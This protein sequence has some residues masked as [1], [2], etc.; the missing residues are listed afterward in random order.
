MKLVG[1]YRFDTQDVETT[2]GE[3]CGQQVVEVAVPELL[4]RLKTLHRTTDCDVN[5][6]TRRRACGGVCVVCR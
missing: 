4:Q 6:G 5:D 1:A 2:G 3:V